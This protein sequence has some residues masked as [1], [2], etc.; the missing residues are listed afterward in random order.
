MRFVIPLI[1][2]IVGCAVLIAL[3]V[4]QVQ[5]LTW[6]QE[7]LSQIES[8]IAADPVPLPAAP[9]AGDDRYLPVQIAG[10]TTGDELHV[11]ASVKEMGAVYRVISAVDTVEGR[12]VL[13]DLGVIATPA[14]DAPRPPQEV[15][16]IGNLHWPEETDGF[17]PDP[18]RD[19]NIWF[20]RDVAAMSAALR[21]EPFM[22]VARAIT[23]DVPG[24]TPLPVGTEGIPNDHLQYAMTWFSLALIWAGMTAFLLSRMRRVGPHARTSE[25]H[26]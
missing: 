6:K 24:I 7:V 16:I 3:G 10:Q 15:A 9:Q 25:E 23:P 22:I 5:R 26:R 2:G 13:V 21:A 1:F 14:K 17:T 8:R 12:R 19:A 20:A 18:D 4:W 11:L